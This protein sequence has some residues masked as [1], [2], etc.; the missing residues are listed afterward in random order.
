MP[1]TTLL[2][3]SQTDG[4]NGGRSAGAV[5]LPAAAPGAAGESPGR[6][7]E[8]EAG[9]VREGGGESG[10]EGPCAKFRGG[11]PPEHAEEQHQGQDHGCGQRHWNDEQPREE[12]V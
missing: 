12:F 7:S 4:S 9:D 11:S 5:R 10:L 8:G 6:G 2:W 3:L 1:T